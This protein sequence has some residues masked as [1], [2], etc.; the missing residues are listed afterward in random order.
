MAHTEK[1]SEQMSK[2]NIPFEL[3]NMTREQTFKW[4]T[5]IYTMHSSTRKMG[6]SCHRRILNQT[7]DFYKNPTVEVNCWSQML[8][9]N[10]NQAS[11]R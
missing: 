5:P 7:L 6:N 8:A 10:Q 4:T 2:V 9:L 1:Y 11:N 3:Y